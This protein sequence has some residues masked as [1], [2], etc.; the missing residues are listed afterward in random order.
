MRAES[1]RLDLATDLAHLLFGGLRLHY[2]QHRVLLLGNCQSN[3]CAL[4]IAMT[5][6]F[7]LLCSTH[8]D[9][10]GARG[11]GHPEASCSEH[12]SPAYVAPNWDSYFDLR[13]SGNCRG[14]RVSPRLQ[15]VPDVFFFRSE[16][17]T[18]ELQS[19]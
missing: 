13:R 8:G 4:R 6:H 9:Q 7:V 16:E 15:H 12:A 2:D 10:V 18:S 5:R 1:D 3:E 19:R 17:H 11:E 14:T